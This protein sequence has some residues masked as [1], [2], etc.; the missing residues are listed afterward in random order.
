[1]ASSRSTKLRIAASVLFATGFFDAIAGRFLFEPRLT[2]PRP[3]I[4]LPGEEWVDLAGAIHAHSTYSDGAG[5]VPTVLAGAR[6]AGADFLLLTDHNTQQPLRDG[7]EEKYALSRPFLLIGTEVTVEHGAFVLALDMPAAWEPTKAQKPQVAIDE[8]RAQGGLPLV[9]LPFDVKHPWRDWNATGFEGLEVINFSTIARRH[10]NL[11]SLAWLI[12]LYHLRG[13][14]AVLRALVTRPDQAMARWDGL[15]AG[16]ERHFVGI[17]ALDAHA[18]M[19]I[20]KKKYPIPSYADSFRAVMTHFLLRRGDTEGDPERRKRAVYDALHTGRC[21]FS[22][23]CL[24][25]PPRFEFTA[26]NKTDGSVVRMGGDAPPGTE[27]AI[28]G[29]GA[30]T[31]IRLFRDG[32]P[33]AGSVTG[34]L[35]HRADV[36]GAYRIEVS[37]YTLRLGPF[38]FGAR[39]WI[40]T[41]PIY[42]S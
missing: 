3:G 9:S 36:P 12:P 29:F 42:I 4:P 14:Q 28:S 22:Y 25:R 21:Y 24:G 11:L 8:V 35:T 1:M 18:L 17:G 31:L 41:N 32:G 39:P 6:E 20:G 2:D 13:M 19:K 37:R 16:G 30:R 38:F 27:L 5:D 40:F 10:I 7:W 33:V 15:T 23:D 34:G 26:R